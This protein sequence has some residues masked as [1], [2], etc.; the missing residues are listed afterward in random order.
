VSNITKI[1]LFS[2][3][4][5]LIY[6]DVAFKASDKFEKKGYY[7][8]EHI[9]GEGY[10]YYFNSNDSRT[11]LWRGTKGVGLEFYDLRL[12]DTVVLY[13][14]SNYKAHYLG[15]TL[16]YVHNDIRKEK[17]MNRE[18]KIKKKKSNNHTRGF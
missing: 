10:V 15:P 2:S 5:F 13:N 12:K 3:F 9:A 6:C 17:A 18:N 16:V 1:F 11:L 14:D 7:R 4:L 8:V